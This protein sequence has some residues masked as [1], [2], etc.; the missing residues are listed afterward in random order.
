MRR[1]GLVDYRPRRIAAADGPESGLG[2]RFG[3]HADDKDDLDHVHD[4]QRRRLVA[5]LEL[6]RIVG[7]GIGDRGLE[8]ERLRG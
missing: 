3:A 4:E 2:Q 8:L 5:G 1:R 6:G 7:D